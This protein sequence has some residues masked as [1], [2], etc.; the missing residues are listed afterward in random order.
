MKYEN[1][2]DLLPPELLKQ[3]QK[4][5]AGRTIYIP[6]MGKV[7]WGE[8]SGYRRYLWERNE[9]IRARF[10][11][12][13]TAETLAE[14]FCLSEDS[15]R[16][17]TYKKEEPVLD[18]ECSLTNCKRFA[19]AGRLE[20]W[21]HAYLLSDGDNPP[22]SHGL[23]LFDRFFLGPVE[24]PLSLF[25]R[26][27]GPEEGMKWQVNPVHFENKVQRLMETAATD[28]ETPPLIIHYLFSEKDGTPEFELNDG[29][30][31]F[32]AYTRLGRTHTPVIFWITEKAELEDFQKR[33]GWLLEEQSEN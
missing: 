2:K 3:V 23:K 28:P 16:K 7:S 18:Y 14:V 32:E 11:Q 33:Y 12:G 5:A 9:E 4:Y 27:C 26:C 25:H 30:G 24:A 15:I 17:I 13:E 31:R 29:N 8:S 21:V 1:G 22:F 10:R 20:D 19:A 6:S